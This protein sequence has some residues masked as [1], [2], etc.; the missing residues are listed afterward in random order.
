VT[1]RSGVKNTDGSEEYVAYFTLEDLDLNLH[2]RGN[3]KSRVCALLSA[4]F[5]TFL[6]TQ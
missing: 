6:I 3:F 4:V 1:P 2:S 5:I